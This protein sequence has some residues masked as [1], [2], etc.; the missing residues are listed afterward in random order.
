MSE[1]LFKEFSRI[2]APNPSL[3]M[4]AEGLRPMSG[5]GGEKAELKDVVESALA[6][7]CPKISNISNLVEHRFACVGGGFGDVLCVV[8]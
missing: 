7:M 4:S 8:G 3:R 2:G 5:F 1:S 6:D